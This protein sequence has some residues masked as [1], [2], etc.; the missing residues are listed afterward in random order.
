MLELETDPGF[1][2]RPRETPPTPTVYD[3]YLSTLPAVSLAHAALT[4]VLTRSVA[5]FSW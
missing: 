4:G 1:V 2:P 5:R 3:R